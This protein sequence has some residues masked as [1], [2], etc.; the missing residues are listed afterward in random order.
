MIVATKKAE[1][2]PVD[3]FSEARLINFLKNACKEDV[4]INTHVN[5]R[6][7]ENLAGTDLSKINEENI[8]LEIVAGSQKIL[9]ETH[10]WRSEE[11]SQEL[12]YKQVFEYKLKNIEHEKWQDYYFV[13]TMYD[14]YLYFIIFPERQPRHPFDKEIIKKFL[15][16]WVRDEKY[17]PFPN[18]KMLL[19]ED[20]LSRLEYLKP[21]NF[22]D[23][24]RCYVIPNKF[25]K[26]RRGKK[27][28]LLLN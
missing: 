4:V 23:I 2:I 7:T 12:S 13:M 15:G 19:R 21:E 11:I 26:K 22:L 18:F 28:L 27:Y 10:F 5:T 20:I 9:L 17:A 14:Y 24:F 1:T 3:S 25:Y 6:R 8:D 16:C